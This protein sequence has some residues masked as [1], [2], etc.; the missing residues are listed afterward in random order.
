MNLGSGFLFPLLADLLLIAAPSFLLAVV[1]LIV[2][3]RRPGSGVA[4]AWCGA[5]AAV[6]AGTMLLGDFGWVLALPAALI[7]AFAVYRAF[8][9]SA[10]AAERGE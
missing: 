7:L 10:A 9:R 6:T 2:A 3:R 5:A 1:A 8:R 4:K